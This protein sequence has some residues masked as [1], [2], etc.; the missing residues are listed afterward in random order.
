MKRILR[1]TNPDDFT[2]TPAGLRPAGRAVCVAPV[3]RVMRCARRRVFAS[4]A[5]RGGGAVGD[6]PLAT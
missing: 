4:V 5:A 6:Y 1:A 3:L 2:G